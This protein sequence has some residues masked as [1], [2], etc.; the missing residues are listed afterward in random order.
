MT[1]AQRADGPSACPGNSL[2]ERGR[3]GG[4]APPGTCSK[5][6][7]PSRAERRAKYLLLWRAAFERRKS[8]VALP[9]AL[10]EQ[11]VACASCAGRQV[12][13]LRV[14]IPGA[15]GAVKRPGVPYA[16]SGETESKETGFPRAGQRTEAMTRDYTSV[17]QPEERR[18]ATRLEGRGQ[19]ASRKRTGRILRDARKGA[20]L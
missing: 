1:P 6:Q 16:P 13:R 15:A 17:P 9:G 3:V 2:H 7:S 5:P 19:G 10:H 20:L 14:D 11:R 4:T 18:E 12:C 8:K